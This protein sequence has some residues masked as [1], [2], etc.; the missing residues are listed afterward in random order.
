MKRFL[1]HIAYLLGVVFTLAACESDVEFSGEQMESLPV[2]NSVVTAGEPVRVY[3]TRSVFILDNRGATYVTDATVELYINDTFVETLRLESDEMLPDETSYHYQATTAPRSGDRVTIRARSEEFP[4]G[5]SGTTVVPHSPA[6]GGVELSVSGTAEWRISGKA[7]L[8]LSD[9]AEEDNYYWMYG[10]V[11]CDHDNPYVMSYEYFTYS[12]VAFSGG[13]NTDVLGEM[14]GDSDSIVV[15]D[16][17]LLAGKSDYRLNMEWGLPEEWVNERV[18]FEIGCQQIDQH[19]YKYY[20]SLDLSDSNSLF[21]E[22]VQIHSNVDGGL[23]IVGS[24]SA[25]TI[26]QKEYSEVAK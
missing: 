15:F 12:D 2:L 10:M 1:Q 22:P 16:D 4:E 18:Y 20:R 13:A 17:T 5:V 7:S 6:V 11:F 3:F 23:G 9:S 24:Q 8:L 26:Y 14:L 19:L 25:L 21:G